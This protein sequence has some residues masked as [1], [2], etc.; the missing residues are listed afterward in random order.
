VELEA[1]P[2]TVDEIYLRIHLMRA[3]SILKLF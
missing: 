2:I 3:R 1:L